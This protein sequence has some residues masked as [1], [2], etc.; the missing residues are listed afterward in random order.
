[1]IFDHSFPNL[2]YKPCDPEKV[3]PNFYFF[4]YCF[5]FINSVVVLFGLIFFHKTQ[6]IVT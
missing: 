3:F 2:P 4:F 5:P 1:M 6:G